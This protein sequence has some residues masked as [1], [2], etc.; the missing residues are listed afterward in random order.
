L[1]KQQQGHS[2]KYWELLVCISC[3]TYAA[4]DV[5]QSAPDLKPCQKGVIV[6]RGK[7]PRLGQLDLYLQEF[8]GADANSSLDNDALI[9]LVGFTIPKSWQKH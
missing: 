1:G 6:K 4:P 7:K 2:E 8:P 9:E 5:L 3:R